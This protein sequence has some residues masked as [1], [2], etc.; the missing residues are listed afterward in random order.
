MK[1]RTHLIFAFLLFLVTNFYFNYPL[2][3]SIFVVFGTLIPDIDLKF[4][5]LHRKLLHN[6]WIPL[7]AVYFGLEFGILDYKIGILFFV[8]YVS[9][10]ISD[11]MTLSGIMPLWPIKKPRFK[12]KFKTGGLKEYFLVVG[13][14]IV[15]F[16]TI[17]YLK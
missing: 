9:H 1:K 6:I 11:A 17:F 8:G 4:G 16:I 14:L 7:L 5:K 10:L 15:I 12:G 3:Y 2:I 13:L